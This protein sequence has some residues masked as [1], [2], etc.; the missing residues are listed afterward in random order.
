M[1]STLVCFGRHTITSM[2]SASGGQFR[3]WT[4]NYRLFSK[5]RFRAMPVF[6]AARNAVVEALDD[7]APL[8]AGLDDTIVRKTGRQIP[9]VSYRRDPLSPPFQAN[10]VLGQRFLQ[11]SAALPSEGM[12]GPAR[13]I[14]IDFHHAPTAKKPSRGAS[15]KEHEQYRAARRERR[16]SQVGVDRIKHL[17]ASMDVTR[18]LWVVVDGGYTNQTVLSQLPERTVLIGRIRGDAH[19]SHEPDPALSKRVGRR[20]VYGVD[21]PTPREL[22]EDVSI[23]WE[24]HEIR[25]AGQTHSVKCKRVDRL[26]WR[27][28]G[29]KQLLSMIVLA[30]APYRG[31][32]RK[33]RRRQPGFLICTDVSLPTERVLQAYAWRW[34]VEVNFRDEKTLLGV[35]EAQVRNDASVEAAP[36]FSVAAYSLLLLAAARCSSTSLARVEL[37][38][39]KWRRKEEHARPSLQDL[40][41]AMRADLWA[42]SIRCFD[43]FSGLASNRPVTTK[44]EK[45][46]ASA[47]LYSV[48]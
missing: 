4:A 2:L 27:G 28:A 5:R 22:L 37:P 20:C 31:L 34:D 13:M 41:N 44:P 8:V 36:A 14:P 43:G 33:L 3:D 45:H 11:I 10:L 7:G 42:D 1:F 6:D 12:T 26:R 9:G 46:L 47:A 21:A 18:D 32:R 48:A 16:L 35:G 24:E 25:V 38:P 29:G 30:P 40:V 19:L 39:P 17:R 15:D 23:P